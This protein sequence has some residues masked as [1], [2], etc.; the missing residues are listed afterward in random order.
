MNRTLIA[1]ISLLMPSGLEANAQPSPEFSFVMAADRCIQWAEGRSEIPRQLD[2]WEYVDGPPTS[3]STAFF[4]RSASGP[5]R[6]DSGSLMLQEEFYPDILARGCS[7]TWSSTGSLTGWGELV[8]ELS[9]AGFTA[10]HGAEGGG[11]ILRASRV[12]GPLTT[13]VR[14]AQQSEQSN[15]FHEA[16][17]QF[18]L[19]NVATAS[20]HVSVSRSNRH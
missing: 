19:R 15:V 8:A 1:A 9:A 3:T 16:T 14:F 4:S 6:N 11:Q 10:E 13:L 12:D 20:L 7:E 5:D 2:G 17:A 18:A